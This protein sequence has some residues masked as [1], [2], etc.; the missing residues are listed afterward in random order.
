MENFEEARHLLEPKWNQYTAFKVLSQE[1]ANLHQWWKNHA[2][3][4]PTFYLLAKLYLF[5]PATSA[6]P[7]RMFSKARRVL[8]GSVSS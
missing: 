4:F 8:D 2:E 3:E 6:G 1:D 5:V 7:K